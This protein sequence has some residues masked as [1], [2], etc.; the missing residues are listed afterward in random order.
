MAN[1]PKCGDFVLRFG[2]KCDT[3]ATPGVANKCVTAG[4]ADYCWRRN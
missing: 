3:T 2:T 1:D 4:D